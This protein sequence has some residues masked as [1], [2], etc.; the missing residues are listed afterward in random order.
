MCARCG[1]TH[2]SMGAHWILCFVSLTIQLQDS[3][4]SKSATALMGGPGS[5]LAFHL[6]VLC[7]F[8]SVHFSALSG[9]QTISCLPMHKALTHLAF[10]LLSLK[11]TSNP[12]PLG[13][14]VLIFNPSIWE[15]ERGGDVCA[16]GQLGQQNKF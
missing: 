14:V 5:H 12:L 15:V 4:P 10:L 2:R 1:A 8:R 11:P 3:L 6:T 16:H 7:D 9:T 13:M